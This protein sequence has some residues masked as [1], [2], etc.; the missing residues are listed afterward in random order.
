MP[1]EFTVAIKPTPSIGISQKTV[2]FKTLKEEKI[3]IKGRHDPCIVPRAIVVVEAM[4]AVV[5]LDHLLMEGKIPQI[6]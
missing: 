3:E 1:I 2:N 4:V 5:L 6:L